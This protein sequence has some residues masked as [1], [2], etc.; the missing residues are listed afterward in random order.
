MR[1]APDYSSDTFRPKKF[2]YLDFISK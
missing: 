2:D 1:K